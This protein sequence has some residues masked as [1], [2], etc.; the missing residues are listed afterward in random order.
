MMMM[1]MMIIITII[2]CFTIVYSN[3][4]WGPAPLQLKIKRDKSSDAQYLSTEVPKYE[5]TSWGQHSG[6]GY[7]G[8]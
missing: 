2:I 3:G 6:L 1:M 8:D 5:T 4:L 7:T